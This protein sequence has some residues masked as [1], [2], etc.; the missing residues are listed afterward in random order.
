MAAYLSRGVAVGATVYTGHD[1]LVLRREGSSAAD[2]LGAGL[3]ATYAPAPTGLRA[4][5]AVT[6]NRLQL[7]TDRH[8]LNGSTAIVSSAGKRDGKGVGVLGNVGWGVALN[9][10]VIVRPFAELQ[11]SRVRLDGYGEQGGPFPV[12][13]N[14]MSRSETVAR[15]G[16]EVQWQVRP[17]LDAYASAAWAQRIA[18]S[19]DA[20][21]GTIS[22]LGKVTGSAGA[23]PRA[24]A[25]MALGLGWQ[26]QPATRIT[27]SVGARAGH[28]TLPQVSGGVG[29]S[30]AF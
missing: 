15:L 2:S 21:T 5:L 4:L 18:E 29:V 11:W 27:A 9:D 17:G 23:P 12:Q 25:E 19:A 6:A 16:T 22:G 20:P 7:D 1:S 30:F 13:W 3:F 24:A 10:A 8:T 28:S 14:S 26:V